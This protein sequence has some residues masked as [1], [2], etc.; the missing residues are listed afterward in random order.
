MF[1]VLAVFAGWYAEQ[2]GLMKILPGQSIEL[3][4]DGSGDGLIPET[5]RAWREA[6]AKVDGR[7]QPYPQKAGAQERL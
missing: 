4:T 1:V 5:L 2:T 7:S 6:E 3:D